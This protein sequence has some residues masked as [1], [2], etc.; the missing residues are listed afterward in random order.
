M[1]GEVA[2][3]EHGDNRKWFHFPFYDAGSVWTTFDTGCGPSLVRISTLLVG[4]R[5]SKRESTQLRHA[6]RGTKSIRGAAFHLAE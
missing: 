3:S 4:R 5:V 1:S 6:K 2:V